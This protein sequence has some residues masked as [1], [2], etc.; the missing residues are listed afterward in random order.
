MGIVL[1]VSDARRSTHLL[2]G[3]IHFRVGRSDDEA[4]SCLASRQHGIVARGQLLDLGMGQRAIDHRL[5]R[6]RLRRLHPGVYAVGHEAIP[7]PGRVV[8]AV[9]SVAPAAASHLTAAALW[10]ITDPS[11][12]AI[13]VT[14]A[15]SRRPRCRIIIHRAVLPAEDLEIV[16]GIPTTS[17]SRTLLDLSVTSQESFVRR[18]LKQAEFLNLTSAAELVRILGRYP[19]RRG[20]R[21]LARI[22]ER[23]AASAGRTRS[24]FEDRFLEF[25]M[26]RGLPLPETN[27]ALEIRGRRVE[28][29]CVWESRKLI[30]ELDGYHAH[31]SASAFHDDR[32]RDRAL[33]AAGWSPMRITWAQ[34][35]H[36]P[37]A[38]EAEL[39]DTLKL[40]P[41]TPVPRTSAE[42]PTQ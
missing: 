13:H 38:L 2:C 30:V 34:F 21:V 35:H 6:G 39:R 22:V 12:G 10:R 3:D 31:S 16:D 9:M 26:Q 8:A 5:A 28:V 14:A 36:E 40:G 1:A 42:R 11:A 15:Q 41:Q 32:A 4:I 33:I 24:E 29:D 18:L 27:V 19:R 23:Y 25:C 20:R 17:V 37:D 7:Y